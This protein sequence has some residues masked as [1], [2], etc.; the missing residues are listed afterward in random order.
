MAFK[1]ELLKKIKIDDLTDKVLASIGPAGSEKKADKGLFRI[2]LEMAGYIHKKERD[3]DLYIPAKD[4]N[5]AH[6]LVLDNDLAFYNTSI[7]DIGLRK[8]P[9][10]KEMISIRN[11]IKILNDKDV[12]VSKKADSVRTVQKEC[13]QGLDLSFSPDDIESIAKDGAAS[14]EHGYAEGVMECIDIFAELLGYK[15]APKAFR[16]DHHRILGAFLQNE[17]GDIFFG[18]VV[19]YSFIYNRLFAML[20]PVGSFDKTGMEGYQEVLKGNEKPDLSGSDVFQFLKEEVLNKGYSP[21][22]TINL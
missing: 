7:S 18:P 10:L 19:F 1:Q 13:L 16:A 14:L 20:S 15:P 4:K 2:L 21:V 3:L 8:S 17:K 5:K 9:T 12:V 22:L 11:A 6:I